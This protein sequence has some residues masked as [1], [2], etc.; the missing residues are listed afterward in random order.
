MRELGVDGL[1]DDRRFLVVRD[2]STGEQFHAP[3][4]DQVVEDL[5][6][7]RS[8]PT[9]GP[10]GSAVPNDSTGSEQPMETTL[11]PREI[12]ARI[13]RGESPAGVADATGMDLAQIEPFAGP[14]L[15]ER[16]FM[17]QQAR[18]TTVRRKHATGAGLPLDALVDDA[19]RARNQSPDDVAWD[20]FRREDGRWTVLATLPGGDA[21]A[22]FLYDVAG[23]YVVPA[24]DIAHDLIGDL[25]LPESPDMA[26]ADAIRE[27]AAAAPAEPEAEVDAPADEPAQ[28]TAE[29]ELDL[30][31][32]LDIAAAESL[33]D[34]A[35]PYPPVSSLKEARDRRAQ[36]VMAQQDDDEPT[37]DEDLRDHL[38]DAVIEHDIAVPDASSPQSKKRHER[39]RVPSWD[40]I[41]FGDRQD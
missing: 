21:S 1:T 32:P 31:L 6:A 34:Q 13:R 26:L 16:E 8:Q 2:P 22:T 41:M 33:L 30:D 17:A 3:L 18:R 19:L 29:L 27:E 10:A 28:P 5:L 7:S 37:I 11:T 12:Q 36:T 23:R 9:S 39:R 35:D 14:V 25:A 38:E 4:D 15:D 40:E 24:D 20:A